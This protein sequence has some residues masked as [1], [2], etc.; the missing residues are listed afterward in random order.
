MLPYVRYTIMCNDTP[1]DPAYLLTPSPSPT[2]KPTPTALPP[3]PQQTTHASRC[4][5]LQPTQRK[6]GAAQHTWGAGRMSTSL[7]M[8]TQVQAYSRACCSVCVGC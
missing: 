7:C 3:L 2:H 6:P 8:D 5:S 1:Q 4:V